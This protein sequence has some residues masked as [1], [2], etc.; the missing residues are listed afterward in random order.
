M[1]KMEKKGQTVCS[2]ILTETINSMHI[3]FRHTIYKCMS[4]RADL[5]EHRAKQSRTG[6]FCSFNKNVYANG[7]WNGFRINCDDVNTSSILFT[8]HFQIVLQNEHTFW[9]NEQWTRE[10]TCY[11]LFK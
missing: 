6:Q 8:K 3:L 4:G 5:T 1:E 2:V 10:I 9:D 11:H 7:N